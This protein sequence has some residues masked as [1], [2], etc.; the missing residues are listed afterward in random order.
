MTPTPPQTACHCVLQFNFT[1]AHFP[2]KTKTATD[3]SSRLKMD[4]IEN[5][6]VK[7]R[8]DIPTRP[9]EV[10]KGSTGLAQNQ[11]VFLITQTYMRPPKKATD[12]Q[13]RNRPRHAN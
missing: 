6:I 4:T 13:R 7:I 1:I 3:L 9:I 5:K 2:A 11:Q 12:T 10:D 8:E